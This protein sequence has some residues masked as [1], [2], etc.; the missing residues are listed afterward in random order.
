MLAPSPSPRSATARPFS[1][2]TA[3]PA[4]AGSPAPPPASPA[5]PSG[6]TAA[7]T[8][9][10]AAA[11]AASSRRSRSVGRDAAPPPHTPPVA[12]PPQLTAGRPTP[13]PAGSRTP[14]F[15]PAVA[16]A[17]AHGPGDMPHA[18]QPSLFPLGSPGVPQRPSELQPFSL[19]TLDAPSHT[20]A[21][22]PVTP[23][24]HLAASPAAA[25]PACCVFPLAAAAVKASPGLSAGGQRSPAGTAAPAHT[26]ASAEGAPQ[27][28]PPRKRLR[29]SVKPLRDEPHVALH[30]PPRRDGLLG[31]A[32]VVAR[33]RRS[34]PALHRS[35]SCRPWVDAQVQ[36]LMSA[37]HSQAAACKTLD[38]LPWPYFD[39]LYTVP[40]LVAFC[41]G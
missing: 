34:R 18:P 22:A 21:D 27:G 23:Q 25:P 5:P 1:P 10:S 11:A 20:A 40:S 17:V 3:S 8:A 13:E 35:A 38:L 7:T 32:V 37:A 15:A 36:P 33:G 26:A 4:A 29:I 14:D 41:P 39:Q 19:S 2:K 9:V 16:A 28:S 30:P 24:P 6:P 31:P 12:A